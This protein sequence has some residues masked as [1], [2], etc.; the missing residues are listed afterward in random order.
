M[1]KFLKKSLFLNIV[2]VLSFRKKMRFFL[3]FK[4]HSIVIKLK[5]V[6]NVYISSF[7]IV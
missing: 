7:K 4:M 2:L 1:L 6:T 5:V 3:E